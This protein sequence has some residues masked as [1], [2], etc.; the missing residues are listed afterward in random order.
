MRGHVTRYKS[1]LTLGLY[2]LYPHSKSSLE[3]SAQSIST[4][5]CRS[6]TRNPPYKIYKI[7]HLY[8]D[9]ILYYGIFSTTF[10]KKRYFILMFTSLPALDASRFPDH[11]AHLVCQN[12][13]KN[14]RVMGQNVFPQIAKQNKLQ[15]MCAY[16]LCVRMCACVY[17]YVRVCN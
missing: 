17:V 14:K 16:V 4:K 9:G 11:F 5:D 1:R 8:F 2:I 6:S 10:P 15:F 13:K 12:R 3:V 7:K